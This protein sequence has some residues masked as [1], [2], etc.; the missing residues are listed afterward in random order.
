M[1]QIKKTSCLQNGLVW[2]GAGV[3]IAEIITGTYFAELGFKT[4]L[5]AILVGHLIGGVLFFLAGLIGAVTK[6]SS[7]Q[8]C[9]ISFG[10]MGAVFFAILNIVQLVGWTSI[11][12][13]DGASITKEI[14]SINHLVWCVIIGLLIFLWIFFGVKDLGV[15][16]KIAMGLFL[17]TKLL[18]Q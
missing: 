15:I 9:S 2:F 3:S 14:S 16:N 8:T 7:M 13:Y 12:I 5:T 4:G 10:R 1:E 17:E 18:I 11:M 6:K